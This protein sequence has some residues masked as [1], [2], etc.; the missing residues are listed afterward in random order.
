MS[1]RRSA[2]ARSGRGLAIFTSL[3]LVAMV[4]CSLL[5]AIATRYRPG[6]DNRE[7]RL[8]IAYS[9][10]KEELFTQL[11]TS[12]NGEKKTLANG[13]RVTLSLAKL[14][15]E[16]MVEAAG[17]NLYQ[18]IHPDSSVW[19]AQ[20]DRL[21]REEGET[22]PGDTGLVGETVRYMVS[23]VVIAMWKDVAFSLGYPE[24][25]LGWQDL[26][27][28]ALINPQFKWSHP[29]TNSAS[30]LL[31]TLAAFYAG[32][33]VTR[34]LTA[35]MATAQRTLDYVGTL[36][37]TV[38]HYGE[39]ELAV[40]Q[41]IEEQGRGFLDAFV[42]QEQL[43]IRHNL[44]H[45]ADLVAIY[46]F[47][48]TLWED[49]PL[50]LIEH[51]QRSDEERQAF[52][53]LKAFLLSPEVQRTVLRQG[54]RPTDL[55]IPLDGPDSPLKPENGVDPAQPYTT[56]QIPSPS[57]IEVVKDVW[58]YT[59]R[60]TNIY[61]VVDTSGSMDGSKLADAQEALKLFI[62]QIQG[63]QE[64]VGLITFASGVHERV[65]L[66]KLGEGRERLLREIDDLEA[67]GQTAMLDGVSL[68]L[69]RLR[70]LDDRERIN[71]IVVMSDGKENRSSTTLRALVQELRRSAVTA[72]GDYVPVVVFCIAYGRDADYQMLTAISEASG[73]FT[74]RGEL[75]TIQD[76]YK[77]LS[78]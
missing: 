8:R 50:V 2:G 16:E 56:L 54:Y 72:Q 53:L 36:E 15:P 70:E 1:R 61:L 78:T 17:Q 27:H 38:K 76:L 60:H 59:K 49:H 66:T 42:V 41:Q 55:S 13:K 74:R 11:A 23:P 6:H 32:A 45:G 22:A 43:V 33:N 24:K 31:A 37:K 19:L 51:T 29:S 26:L 25:A 63:D 21:R 62:A 46:P 7:V 44:R 5:A 34:G 28:T 35:E 3:V 58:W 9:P 10:E 14:T 75:G 67:G 4:L 52:A 65:P 18:A 57:V 64:S 73:G 20:I 39:G 12:F 30:G 68:A 48:G 47:E 71:A 40:M 77:S 69:K